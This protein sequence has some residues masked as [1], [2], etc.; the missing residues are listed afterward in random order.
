MRL[1]FNQAMGFEFVDN[2]GGVG[3]VDAI[4]LGK[5]GEGR[6]SVAE[7]KEDFAS[8]GPEAEPER[9]RKVAVAVVRINELLHQGPGLRGG[10]GRSIGARCCDVAS[11]GSHHG[12][13]RP[14]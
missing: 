6:R 2:E 3:G 11:L 12:T 4:G 8:P 10:T 7:L 1:A 13:V 5:F 14:R 9:L